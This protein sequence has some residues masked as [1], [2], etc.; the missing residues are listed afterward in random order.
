MFRRPTAVL[1]AALLMILSFMVFTLGQSLAELAKQEKERRAQVNAKVRV[2]SNSDVAKFQKGAV[3]T[4]VYGEQPNK[5]V[6]VEPLPTPD[7]ARGAASPGGV[8]TSAPPTTAAAAAAAKD[9]AY[10]RVR[11]KELNEKIRAAENKSVL[12]QLQLNELKNRFYS[13]QD[14]FFRETIQKD[15]DKKQAEIENNQKAL[16]AAQKELEDFK[17]EA[18]RNNVPIGWIR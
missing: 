6:S 17:K 2:T 1:V 4:G 5:P 11:S 13:E 9:E 10:W 3:T 8:G 18:R 16:Q 14:G 7:A 12:S 15:L